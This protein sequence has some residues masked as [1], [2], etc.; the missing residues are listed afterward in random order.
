MLHANFPFTVDQRTESRVPVSITGCVRRLGRMKSDAEFLNLSPSGFKMQTSTEL[1]VG[2][3][4]WITMPRIGTVPAFVRWKQDDQYGCEFRTPLSPAVVY[5]P[6][7]TE[8]A[9]D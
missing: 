5:M 1:E 6:A 4:L 8:T 2:E 3:L 9:N 7:G